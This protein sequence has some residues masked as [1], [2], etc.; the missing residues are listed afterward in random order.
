MRRPTPV[1]VGLRSVGAR[2]QVGRDNGWSG[3]CRGAIY[4][5]RVRI[6]GQSLPV[7]AGLSRL[8]ESVNIIPAGCVGVNIINLS[9]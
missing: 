4:S 6:S 1:G 9:K 8:P 3:R 7:P 5:R 2:I